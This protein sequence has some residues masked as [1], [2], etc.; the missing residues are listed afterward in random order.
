MLSCRLSLFAPLLLSERFFAATANIDFCVD[1]NDAAAAAGEEL[2]QYDFCTKWGIP[3]RTRLESSRAN[4]L[5]E[6][7]YKRGKQQRPP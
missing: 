6:A 7:V 4:G 2:A 5:P 1:S 3:Q